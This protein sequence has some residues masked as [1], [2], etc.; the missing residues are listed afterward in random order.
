MCDTHKKNTTVNEGEVV[1]LH[2]HCVI[3]FFLNYFYHWWCHHLHDLGAF[4]VPYLRLADHM[5]LRDAVF[6]LTAMSPLSPLQLW[7]N[8][9]PYLQKW[10]RGSR[11]MVCKL[12]RDLTSLLL[13]KT[14]FTNMHNGEKHKFACKL[15]MLPSTY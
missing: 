13:L 14:F 12:Y 6:S 7:V 3:S 15:R 2:F 1:S 8:V 5:V 10:G 9:L 11:M 4:S